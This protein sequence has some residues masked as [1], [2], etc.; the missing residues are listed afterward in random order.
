MTS[1]VKLFMVRALSA[2]CWSLCSAMVRSSVSKSFICWESSSFQDSRSEIIWGEKK[3]DNVQV[4]VTQHTFI[5]NVA[6]TMEVRNWS[7]SLLIDFTDQVQRGSD[8][9][10]FR[11]DFK[12]QKTDWKNLFE[13]HYSSPSSSACNTIS[14]LALFKVLLH[15]HF[16]CENVK[17]FLSPLLK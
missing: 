8:T 9:G 7:C 16:T 15:Q 12:F 10:C 4:P 13:N 5:S 6:L 2:W 17:M 11:M 1:K 3:D 14:S